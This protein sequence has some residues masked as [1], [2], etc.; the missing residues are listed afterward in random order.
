MSFGQNQNTTT[1]TN[2]N[3]TPNERPQG[4]DDVFNKI[5]FSSVKLGETKQGS[6]TVGLYLGRDQMEKLQG[7]I[8]EL[9]STEVGNNGCKVSV[10]CIE[11]KDYNSGYAYVNPKEPKRDGN[12]NYGGQTRQQGGNQYSKSRAPGNFADKSSA[13]SFLESKRLNDGTQN[14]S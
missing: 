10:I 7:L 14:K 11:G 2:Q 1:K 9:L 8:N 5:S 13:R 12:N 3:T 6:L 4:K